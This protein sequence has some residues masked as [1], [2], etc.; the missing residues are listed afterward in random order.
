MNTLSP[1]PAFATRPDTGS[2]HNA[3]PTS[4]WVVTGVIVRR[5]LL[6]FV[7]QPSRIAAAIGTPCLLW[8]FLGSGFAQSFRAPAQLGEASYA[9]YLLPGMMT[10]V[11]VFAAIFSSISIIED[12]REGWL[13]S[14]LVSPAPRWSIALGKTLGGAIVAWVQAALLL[15]AAPLL[16]IHLTFGAVLLTL[17]AV[18]VTSIAMTAIGVAFA[19]RTETTAAFHAVMNLVFM[20]AWLLSGALFPPQ[21][22]A[23]WL[24]VVVHLNPLSWCTQAIRG[25]LLGQPSLLALVGSLVFAGAA[26]AWATWVVS[27]PTKR[28][29]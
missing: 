3:S 16:D 23:G 9:S 8:L 13:Q 20:P 25:P 5:E 18:A 12:R 28:T 29:A 6:L 19:W 2:I 27:A 15:A 7:R 26:I 17:F 11:A 22:A 4:P 24:E 21:G 14:V 1:Q 10:L